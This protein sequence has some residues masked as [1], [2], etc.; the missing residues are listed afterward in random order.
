MKII[1]SR[2]FLSVLKFKNK[3][4]F[5]EKYFADKPAHS[6]VKNGHSAELICQNV[7]LNLA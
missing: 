5:I 3:T 4:D 6:V 2:D 1:F 7:L